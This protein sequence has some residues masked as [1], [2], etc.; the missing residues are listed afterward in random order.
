M[1]LHLLQ[2]GQA[3]RCGLLVS[4]VVLVVACGT[5]RVPLP[6]VTPTATPYPVAGSVITREDF[7]EE[8][9]LTVREAY[10][11]CAQPNVV[12]VRLGQT[13]YPINEKSKFWLPRLKPGAAI[14]DLDRIRIHG[15]SIAGLIIEGLDLCEAASSP[16]SSATPTATTTSTPRFMLTPTSTSTQTTGEALWEILGPP[17]DCERADAMTERAKLSIWNALVTAQDRAAERADR[18]G[19]PVD[20]D[21]INRAVAD[22]FDISVDT[23]ECILLEGG[24]EWWPLPPLP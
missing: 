12:W 19:V 23:S 13:L 22:R 1:P 8:W 7:G 14:R 9:P 5:D 18:L 10:L 2:P 20:Y 16:S 24:R 11:F 15:R 4:L 17:P 21:A 3:G 6:T